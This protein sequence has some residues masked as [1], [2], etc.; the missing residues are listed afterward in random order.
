MTSI[1]VKDVG[2]VFVNTS[3]AQGSS[4]GKAG[5]FQAVWD[6][7]TGKGVQTGV[8]ER[9]VEP[10]AETGNAEDAGKDR[11]ETVKEPSKPDKVENDSKVREESKVS[12]AEEVTEADELTDEELTEVLEV[13]G[14]AAYDLMQQIADVFG[15]S[16]KE[17]QGAMDALGMEQ[18]DV[19]NPSELGNLLLQLGGAQD[20]Y[21]LVTDEAL[22]NN[23]RMLT[24]RL[25]AVLS[26]SAE[27]LGVSA[28][29]L[30]QLL[31]RISEETVEE[32][33]QADMPVIEVIDETADMTTDETDGQ[34][35]VEEINLY[36]ENAE[37]VGFETADTANGA[38]AQGDGEQKAGENVGDRATYQGGEFA[39]QNVRTES[40]ANQVQTAEAAYTD[41]P[42]DAQTQDIMR[43]IMDSMKIQITADTRSMELQLHPAS[44]GNVQVNVAS[45]G[46]AITAKF[47]AENETVKA[48]LE[49]QM[50][51]LRDSFAEQGVKVDA[52]E[53]MVQPHAFERNLDQGRGRDNGQQAPKRNRIRRIRLDDTL[54]VNDLEADE[55]IAA[56]MMAAS[57]STVDYTA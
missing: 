25:N 10:A 48:A 29:D 16:M 7:Q 32:P 4:V 37:S 35:G 39:A 47:I 36:A 2:S 13:L 51:Q 17:L 6:A 54:S 12:E 15:I 18:T 33:A 14:T 42:W 55:R 3:K 53:V 49:T 5:D 38:G 8:R 28:E 22:Y 44:L 11:A 31:A 19:L 41:S 43:Q 20:S 57:G 56:E 24:D 30:N 21:A 46:G 40:F 27:E 23:Y 9:D 52:I 26:E 45:E 50:V 34:N 1:P